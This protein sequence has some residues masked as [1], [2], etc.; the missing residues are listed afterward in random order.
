MMANKQ[1]NPE[2]NQKDKRGINCLLQRPWRMFLTSFKI[3]VGWK[4]FEFWG[5]P[6]SRQWALLQRRCTLGGPN[7]WLCLI[8]GT[9]STPILPD[10]LS[11]RYNGKQVVPRVTRP[12]AMWAF[13]ASNQ[14]LKL[15][16][17][18]NWQPLLLAKFILS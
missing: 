10:G 12:Y 13:I 2:R 1:T 16:P 6:H 3:A 14:H 7:M 4:S 11:G 15:D 5:E 17:V 8:D 9:W 18:A